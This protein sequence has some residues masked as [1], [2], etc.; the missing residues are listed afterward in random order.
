MADAIEIATELVKTFEGCRLKAYADP[1]GIMTIGWGSTGD[2]VYPGLTW[3]QE[4]ADDRLT[5]DVHTFASEIDDMGLGVLTEHQRG[6]LLSFA[7]NV[8]AGALRGSTMARRIKSGRF[9]DAAD[10]FLRWTKAGGRELP[11]L[12]R[13]RKAE[14]AVFMTP[15]E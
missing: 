13:R 6:A 8:G 15:D 7:Y 12:V 4:Q 11:G 14:R 2:D 10:E 1:V 3:T 9:A 5:S